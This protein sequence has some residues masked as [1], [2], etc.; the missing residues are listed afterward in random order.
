[1]LN[2]FLGAACLVL[3]AVASP[4]TAQQAPPPSATV[5]DL[6]GFA[7]Y[8]SDGEKLG[9]VTQVAAT[10]GETVVRAQI[11]GFLG[12]GPSDVIIPSSVFEKKADRIEL[13]MTAAEVKASVEAQRSQKKQNR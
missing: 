3:V 5:V 12:I 9:E 10:S 4:V 1:M 13:S 11:G 2:P 7:V 8:S 6:V